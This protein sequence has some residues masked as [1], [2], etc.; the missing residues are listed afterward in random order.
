[1]IT[2]GSKSYAVYTYKCGMMAW[3]GSAVIGY[4]AAST[5]FENLNISGSSTVNEVACQ[6]LPEEVNNLVYDL[7]PNPSGVQCSLT[8]PEPPRTFGE[9][10]FLKCSNKKGLYNSSN[11]RDKSERV[12]PN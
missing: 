7:V 8:T 4:N 5:Y 12:N 11:K 10:Q 2:D 6:A 9:I 3:S 1:M